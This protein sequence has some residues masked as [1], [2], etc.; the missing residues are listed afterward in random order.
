MKR[1]TL[2][3][4]V[5]YG[6]WQ[7]PGETCQHLGWLG[8]AELPGQGSICA[9]SRVQD[10][11]ARRIDMLPWFYS[12]ESLCC[13][14]EQKASRESLEQK[15]NEVGQTWPADWTAENTG[16]RGYIETREQNVRE[17]ARAGERKERGVGRK[18]GWGEAGTG[19]MPGA[20]GSLAEER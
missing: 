8:E 20:G 4:G 7:K 5:K 3:L 17:S 13:R 19:G 16:H 1:W 14:Y 10:V 9:P 18:M 12:G 11:L 15:E 6:R 2:K